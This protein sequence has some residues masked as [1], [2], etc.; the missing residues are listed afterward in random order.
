MTTLI[1]TS[2][3]LKSEADMNSRESIAVPVGT[4]TGQLVEYSPRGHYLIALTDE[5]HGKVLVQPSNCVIC[6]DKVLL[7]D[8]TSKR[9]GEPKAHYT[10]ESFKKAGDVYGIKY[11]GTP[12]E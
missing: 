10:L 11:I 4:T 8:I 2:D 1:V 12:K 9:A 3:I 5:V 7:S 6:L